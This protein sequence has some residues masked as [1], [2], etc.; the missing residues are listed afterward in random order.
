MIPPHLGLS[1]KGNVMAEAVADREVPLFS[2]QGLAEEPAL[3][4][5]GLRVID[6]GLRLAPG[7]VLDL[8]LA[9][10]ASRPVVVPGESSDGPEALLGRAVGVLAEVRRM[11]SVLDRL[12]PQEGVTFGSDPR[13]ILVARRFSDALHGAAEL[14]APLAIELVEAREIVV[15]GNKRLV[16][17]R[18]GGAAV[19]ANANASPASGA[20]ANATAENGAPLAAA[21]KKK[22]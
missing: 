9:D 18:A 10:R 14:L 2:L 20:A 1:T 12:F 17:V 4:E 16:V 15:E 8:V 7:I 22:G 6:V 21:A 13:L 11:W 3:L 19:T 5:R